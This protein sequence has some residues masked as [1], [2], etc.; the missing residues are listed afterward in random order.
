MFWVLWGWWWWECMH[1]EEKQEEEWHEIC[2]PSRNECALWWM[3]MCFQQMTSNQIHWQCYP[4]KSHPLQ[5]API[6]LQSPFNPISRPSSSSSAST[7][8]QTLSLWFSFVSW[9]L[10]GVPNAYYSSFLPNHSFTWCS[11]QKTSFLII[12]VG[13][14]FLHTCQGWPN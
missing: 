4:K 7:N 9:P 5:L 6:Q 14:A 1:D 11:L 12:V 10:G 13:M 3:R 8:C 2:Q